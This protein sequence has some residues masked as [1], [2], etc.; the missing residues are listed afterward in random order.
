MQN[1]NILAL[2]FK[3]KSVYCMAS[4]LSEGGKYSLNMAT[5]IQPSIGIAPVID[6]SNK[7]NSILVPYKLQNNFFP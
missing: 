5:A 1:S 3:T 2:N 7:M 4:F 6:Q